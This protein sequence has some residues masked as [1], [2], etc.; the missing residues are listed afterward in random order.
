[1]RSHDRLSRVLVTGG[2]GYVG[3][4]VTAKLIDCGYEV[5]VLDNLQEGHLPAIHR[6]ASFVHGDIA[7]AGL[8]CDIFSRHKP[9]AVTHMAA[10]TTVELSMKA[11]E[12][13]FDSNVVKSWR[14]LEVMREYGVTDMIF[15]SS[16]AV[17]GEPQKGEPIAEADPVC[18]INAYGESKLMFERI[19]SWYAKAHGFRYASFRYFNAAGAHGE[20]GECHRNESHLIPVVLRKATELLQAG[21][22]TPVS[23]FGH[24]YPTP[25]GTC[26]RD[27]I[28]VT[29]IA[30]AHI[31]ALR[32]LDKLDSRVFNLGNGRGFSVLQVIRI[33]EKVTGHAI[34]WVFADRR[35][36][37][38]P[39]LVASARL[40]ETEL[41]WKPTVSSLEQIIASAWEW[42]RAHPR[43]Y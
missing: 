19:L 17:Y 10:E 6:Q 26:V 35:P 22:A 43:G 18:P 5:I 3:S 8:L 38:P 21:K 29:D 36:G 24:D 34:P 1:M 33:A 37:D 30:S 13:Y 23:V 25:D 2:A 11:P 4:V 39:I 28:H 7:D 27:Y 31:M 9:A 32:K 40:A 42:T 41:G 20:F 15:S 16:A 14:L 12:K